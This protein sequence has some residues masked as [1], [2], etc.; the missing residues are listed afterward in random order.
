MAM[1]WFLPCNGSKDRKEIEKKKKQTA[2][3]LRSEAT[4]ATVES[5]SLRDAEHDAR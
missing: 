5:S 4:A 3:K 2:V 1:I